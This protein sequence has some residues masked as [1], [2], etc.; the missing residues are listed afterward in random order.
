[1]TDTDRL[2][3]A[4]WALIHAA[5]DPITYPVFDGHR[6]VILPAAYLE[7]LEEALE[8]V[9]PTEQGGG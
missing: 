9:P 3:Q 4:A 6:V 2:A 1:M 7:Q 5:S 8:A